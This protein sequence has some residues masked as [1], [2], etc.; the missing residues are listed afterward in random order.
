MV[1]ADFSKK[2]T[3]LY[4]RN[5]LEILFIRIYEMVHSAAI[6]IVL[7][8][9]TICLFEGAFGLYCYQCNSL[10]EP[11]CAT[12]TKNSTD[13]IYYQPCRQPLTSQYKPFCR[14]MYQK[15]LVRDGVISIT[16]SC[17]YEKSPKPCYT[18]EDK[19]HEEVVCQCFTDG[20]N[21]ASSS[22]LK[23]L[24]IVFAFIC[25]FTFSSWS[26]LWRSD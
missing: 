11:S 1:V 12:L 20:C 19:D 25:K 15:I 17:S 14:K 10:I 16:R 23:F 6:R 4:R 26:F 5:D 24:A 22:T 7:I 21:G 2:G 8:W 9:S 13:S 3:S 18:Y